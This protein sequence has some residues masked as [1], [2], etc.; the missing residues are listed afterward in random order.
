MHGRK[1][2]KFLYDVCMKYRSFWEEMGEISYMCTGF[3]VKYPL[4]LSDL[5]ESWIFSTDMWKILKYEI[6]RKSVHWNLVV[7]C[8]QTDRQ[9]MKLIFA[10]RNFANTPKTCTSLE[11]VF[12]FSKYNINVT[13]VRNRCVFFVYR[14]WR[15]FKTIHLKSGIVIDHKMYKIYLSLS[16]INMATVRDF[17]A[18][19]NRFL[20][21][22][23][24]ISRILNTNL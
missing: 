2:I 7:P 5:N 14:S 4:F 9:M 8:G 12:L 3:H 16:I 11:C 1:N 21:Q 23:I 19:S 6:S 13:T 24:C 20:V 18:A 17:K 22:K 15:S 10:F